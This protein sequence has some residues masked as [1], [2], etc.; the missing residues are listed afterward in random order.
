[1]DQLGP[2]S[3]LHPMVGGSNNDN[4]NININNTAQGALLTGINKN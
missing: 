4:G 2:A 3:G 1:M